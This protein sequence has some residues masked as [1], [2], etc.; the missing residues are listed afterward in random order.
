[1]VKHLGP[2]FN[3]KGPERTMNK[4]HHTNPDGSVIVEFT[5]TCMT[6]GRAYPTGVNLNQHPE[7]IG[8]R[9][10]VECV[11]RREGE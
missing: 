5:N 3:P 2:E 4:T 10:C 1:M 8:K 7:V 6:C 11:I 9:E